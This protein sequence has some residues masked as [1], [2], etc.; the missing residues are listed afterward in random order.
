[1][2]TYYIE[3]PVVMKLMIGMRAESMEDAK[4]KILE[5]GKISLNPEY[6]EDANIDFVDLEWEIHE[7]VVQGNV[8]YG[9]INELE[10]EL[11]DFL[12]DEDDDQ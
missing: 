10:I 6:K 5:G 2:K 8:Y 9:N 3:A 7:Q 12:D 11:D 4:E 1:M